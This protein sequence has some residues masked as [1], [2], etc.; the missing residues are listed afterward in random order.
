MLHDKNDILIIQTNPRIKNNVIINSSFVFQNNHRIKE[1]T[2]TNNISNKYVYLG[3][4]LYSK[5]DFIVFDN[6]GVLLFEGNTDRYLLT[7]CLRKIQDQPVA[8]HQDWLVSTIS[9]E[10]SRIYNENTS[11][12]YSYTYKDISR[13]LYLD[14]D[15][16]SFRN[17]ISLQKF[18][19]PPPA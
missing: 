13:L 12:K 2:L 16:Y 10:L 3:I 6:I 5:D 19:N 14:L 15:T 1:N 17:F 18:L 11:R 7:Q 8:I 4:S 9:S